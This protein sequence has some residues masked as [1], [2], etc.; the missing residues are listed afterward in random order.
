MLDRTTFMIRLFLSG[1]SDPYRINCPTNPREAGCSVKTSFSLKPIMIS[2][3]LNSTV[4][5]A[6]PQESDFEVGVLHLK[7]IFTVAG[8]IFELPQL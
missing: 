1:L 5:E 8:N 3:Y 4:R 7:H 6:P 2:H